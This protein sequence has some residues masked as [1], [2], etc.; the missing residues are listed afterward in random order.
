MPFTRGSP[1]P[2][3]GGPSGCLAVPVRSTDRYL[4]R[5]DAG[6][7]SAL[8]RTASPFVIEVRFTRGLTERQRA[9]FA[10]AA[11]RWTR[12]VVGDLPEA[13][14]EGETVDDVLI[15]AEGADIDGTGQ[16]LGQAG[17]THLR[18]GSMLP[19]RG[20]MTFDAADLAA[21]EAEGTLDDVIAHE[22]G[23][24]LGVGTLWEQKG[25]LD[26]AGTGDPVFTGAG[27]VAEYAALGGDGPVP[28]E[29]TGGAGTAGG[30]WRESRFGTELMSGFI[31]DAG[32][33]LSRVTAASLA[34]L[35]Y[36]VDLAAAEPYALPPAGPAG[37]SVRGHG[38]RFT[39]GRPLPVVL[40]GSSVRGA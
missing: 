37:S 1:P 33:P 7:A 34:D 32:N 27:A 8:A 35:G 18:P 4:A 19:A 26:G 10:A 25:L 17:P 36:E 24:V 9:A 23:H 22:M 38:G 21:L 30:H 31:R 39:V 29:N 14:I 15:L 20:E 6:R 12:V 13:E 11:D 3:G 2:L 5:A 28:V 16:V 40:P